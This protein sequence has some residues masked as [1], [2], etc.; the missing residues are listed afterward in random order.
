MR[1]LF[2]SGIDGPCHRY[3]VLRRAAQ[4]R[5]S[6]AAVLVRSYRDP[7]LESEA[8]AHD[9]LLLYRVPATVGVLRAID[10]VRAAGGRI[11]G[12]IDDL[13]FSPDESALPPLDHLPAAEQALWRR[14][15]ER[16]RAT[17]AAC[18]AFLGPTEPLV[19]EAASLGWEARLH[20]NAVSP[21]DLAL[22][23]AARGAV[24]SRHGDVV[25]G[26][27]SGTPTHDDDFASI[28][29]ALAAVL[30]EHSRVRLRIVGP[31]RLDAALEPF[32]ARI[33]R[34]EL[35]AWSE[36]PALVASV[37][38]ALAPIDARR[39]FALAKGEVKYLEAA[40]VGTPLVATPTPAFRHA[41]GAGLRGRLAASPDEWRAALDELIRD[42]E[43]SRRL[44]ESARADLEERWSEAARAPELRRALE[45]LPSRERSFEL[46]GVEQETA[47]EIALE[48]DACPASPGVEVAGATPPLGD[49]HLLTQRLAPTRNGL[50][51]VDVHSI[52]CGQRL[53]HELVLRLRRNGAIVGE[54][55]IPAEHAP[56]RSWLAL[57]VPPQ[58]D[59]AHATYDLEIEAHGSGEANAISLGL[60]GGAGISALP[61][62]A[63][64]EG[65]RL[66][67]PLALRCF[68]DWQDALP[69]VPR[70]GSGS[71][72][73]ARGA[74]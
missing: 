41:I 65:R 12:S 21:A 6:G 57:E 32:A 23:S 35:V 7:R 72:S 37:D 74:A 3:Q 29:P 55:A 11:V 66:A 69:A 22:A 16:Y 58:R 49:G 26:Y 47:A 36:L 38:V 33:D 54:R 43:L 13:I 2:A 59:S 31:L 8:P 25:L 50:C 62:P 39:R 19:A 17:L 61:R 28:A 60:A 27:F 5:R 68:A 20:R 71:D 53:R 70:G 14:G 1:V 67:A 24:P 56:D 44:G 9:L 52:T 4:L 40:A 63:E 45:A 18:D 48:P 34:R 30:R 73:R 64:L 42:R 15:V 46:A 51:R 10:R